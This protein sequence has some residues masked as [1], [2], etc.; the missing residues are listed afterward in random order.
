[1]AIINKTNRTHL[2]ETE[3]KFDKFWKSFWNGSKPKIIDDLCLSG[4]ITPALKR[5]IT[6]NINSIIEKKANFKIG[7]TGDAYIRTDHNDYRNGYNNMYL[8]YKSKSD[9]N[10][11]SLEEHYIEKYINDEN[12]NNKNL[13]IKS[14]GKKMYSYDNYYYLYIVTD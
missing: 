3:T 9:K 8:I 6:I 11:S 5:K 12:K 10:I 2:S 4:V 13:R 7:K 14:P 1:M